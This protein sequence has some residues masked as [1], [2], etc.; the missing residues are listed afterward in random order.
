MLGVRALRDLAGGPG[1]QEADARRSAPTGR[2]WLRQGDA[3]GARSCRG[4]LE[5]TARRD[6]GSRP[7]RL[8]CTPPDTSDARGGS[9]L[10][11]QLKPGTSW[12]EVY[13]RARA[14]APE[15]F[16][17]DRILNL[18]GG[19]WQ[20]DRRRRA[21][22]SPRS[23]ARRS[24]ARRGSATTRPSTPS[25]AAARARRLGRRSTSTSASAGSRRPSPRCAST[26]TPSRCC[27]SGRSASRGSWP[28]PTS[29]ARWTA[30]DWY[31]GEIERQL[32][33]RRRCPARSATSPPGTT[34]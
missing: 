26:A 4:T 19:E 7:G 34:R 28:A 2:R 1:A 11:L 24:R 3:C 8:W 5:G 17:A 12:A 25:Q 15:A 20:R 30:C 16:D 31:L 32:Q 27:S 21:S 6:A 23:T 29:T 9:S 33:G 18:A 22:T 14:A 13:A 10:T